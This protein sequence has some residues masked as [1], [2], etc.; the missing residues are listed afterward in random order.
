MFDYQTINHP[1]SLKINPLRRPLPPN[2]NIPGLLVHHTTGM[3]D[4]R[5][6]RGFINSGCGLRLFMLQDSRFFG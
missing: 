2:T 4:V 5:G 6:L 1:S 3:F